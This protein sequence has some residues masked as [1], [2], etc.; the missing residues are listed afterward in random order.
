MVESYILRAE[1]LEVFFPTHRRVKACNMRENKKGLTNV[2]HLLK[3]LLLA[4]DFAAQALH[5]GVAEVT[6]VG[7]A[8][9]RRDAVRGPQGH[10]Q[11]DRQ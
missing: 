10:G 3:V 9:R 7:I 8:R 6:G 11:V 2:D 4:L 5:L 1:K